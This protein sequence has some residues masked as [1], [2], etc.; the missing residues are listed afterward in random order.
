MALGWSLNFSGPSVSSISQ[1]HGATLPVAIQQSSVAKEDT[2]D[3]KE[4]LT[5]PWF[6]TD[7]GGRI[8]T[9]LEYAP[10]LKAA[11]QHEDQ[12]GQ[13]PSSSILFSL[14]ALTECTCRDQ[15]SPTQPRIPRI[16]GTQNRVSAGHFYILLVM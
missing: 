8:A 10:Q 1:G 15:K 16:Q 11:S 4:K 6:T 13:G 7:Q 3:P 9:T 2:Q 14:R 12:G 5:N